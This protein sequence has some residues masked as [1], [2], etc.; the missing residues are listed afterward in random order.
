M[1]VK[2]TVSKEAGLAQ[3][4]RTTMI[5]QFLPVMMVVSKCALPEAW[6]NNLSVVLLECKILIIM[7]YMGVWAVMCGGVQTNVVRCVNLAVGFRN[8]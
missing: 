1:T 6:V 5:L 2:H 3:Q 7:F 8:N 4:K